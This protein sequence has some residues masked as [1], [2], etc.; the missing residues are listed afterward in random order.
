V[1]LFRLCRPSVRTHWRQS[2][3]RQ[4]VAVDIVAKVEHV[5]L[6]R[7]CRKWLIFVARMS[8]VL[9]TPRSILSKVD[10]VEFDFVAS[11]PSLMVM[12][13]DYNDW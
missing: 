1:T 12:A 7:L 2:R 4:L 6:G 11:V 8:N 5:Q 9:S 3:I 10:R 13:E